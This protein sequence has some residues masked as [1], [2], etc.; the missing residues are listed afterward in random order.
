M[1]WR[2]ASSVAGIRDDGTCEVVPVECQ[3]A[4]LRQELLTMHVSFMFILNEGIASGLS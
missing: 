1:V 4:G 3:R 2:K